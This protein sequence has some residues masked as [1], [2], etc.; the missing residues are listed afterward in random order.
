MQAYI[1]F[2]TDGIPGWF[3]VAPIDGA[4]LVD[5]TFIGGDPNPFLASHRRVNGEWVL[6]DPVKVIPPTADEIEAEREA[7]YQAAVATRE[8]AIDAAILASPAYR[9]FIRGDMTLTAYREAASDI[10]AQF[11][12]PVR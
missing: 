3:G 2:T 1:K 9:S 10:E 4:E 11:P 7:V 6:R 5:V 8:D 12:M